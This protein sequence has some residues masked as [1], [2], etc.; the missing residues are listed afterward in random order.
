[1]TI[2]LI[3]V[4]ILLFTF[5]VLAQT[6]DRTVLDLFSEVDKYETQ[7]RQA[8]AQS[9]KRYDASARENILNDK[10]SLA[11]KYVDVAASRT[12]LKGEDY[13]YLGRLYSAAENDQKTLELMRKFVSQYPPTATGDMIQSALVYSVILASRTKQMDL[14]EDAFARWQKGQPMLVSQQ[15]VLQDYIATGYLKDGK[16]ELALKHAQAA[17]DLLK[18]I[19]AKT[20]KEK[21]DREQIYMNLVEVLSL[22]YKKSK[23]TDQA[24]EILAE[25]RAESFALPSANLYRKVMTFVD[26]S[27]F[28][29]K[30]LMQK[31]DAYTTSDPAPEIKISEWIG[32][33]A[34]SLEQLRGKVVL[35]DFWATWCGPCI[36]TFPRLRGWYKKYAGNDFVIIG[37]TQ[38]YGK[39]DDKP[40]SNLQ[41][42]DFLRGFKEKYKMPYSLAV[43]GPNEASI[44]YGIAAL[45]TTIL[46]D[47]N[48]VVRYIGIGAGAEE[49]EN[50]EDTIKKVL[51]EETRVAK[52]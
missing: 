12:D 24:M 21:R 42:L 31:V 4:A 17:F 5:G 3:P 45:P 44:K 16:P 47:R 38:Y 37:V 36:S 11:R 22:G 33:S 25:A 13:Y 50:L 14:A 51:K 6:V 1:M 9:G 34:G 52:N 30:K 26:G 46:L 15:P 8:Y 29:E 48:G 49:S 27:G 40:M 18:S 39:Q 10:K 41:E 23:N 20:A 43:A 2:L 28:S 19:P 7:Q 35:L 32:E